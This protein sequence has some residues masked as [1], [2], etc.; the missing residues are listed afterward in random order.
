[1]KKKDKAEAP[2]KTTKNVVEG[3][4]ATELT[5]VTEQA[6]EARGDEEAKADNGGSASLKPSTFPN[7]DE[8]K[9]R[10]QAKEARVKH[11]ESLGIDPE[12]PAAGPYKVEDAEHDEPMYTGVLTVE[13]TDGQYHKKIST[14][15]D[16]GPTPKG[17]AWL[18]YAFGEHFPSADLSKGITVDEKNE[19]D[20]LL[21]TQH[22]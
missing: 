1:M 2:A 12:A 10:D 15:I 6:K 21:R 16:V 4:K 9:F 7:S 19:T 5:P 22:G 14:R 8:L 20:P 13:G 11:L 17:K 3:S 18:L